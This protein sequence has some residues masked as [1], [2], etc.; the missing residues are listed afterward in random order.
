L[1]KPYGGIPSSGGYSFN[2]ELEIAAARMSE[3]AHCILGSCG[4]A[5]R[6]PGWQRDMYDHMVDSAHVLEEMRLIAGEMVEYSRRY[7]VDDFCEQMSG[8]YGP[9]RVG[10]A[11]ATLEGFQENSPR[12][13]QLALEGKCGLKPK[14]YSNLDVF[15]LADATYD[16]LYYLG[17]VLEEHFDDFKGCPFKTPYK[18]QRLWDAFTNLKDKVE[19]ATKTKVEMKY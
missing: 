14:E 19:T 11:K 13:K 16:F 9:D 4:K 10:Y 18:D 7:Y 6:A 17:E 5:K 8:D 1:D 3:E 12:L 2:T 15:Q